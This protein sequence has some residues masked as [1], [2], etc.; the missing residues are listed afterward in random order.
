MGS[1]MGRSLLSS[2]GS[3]SQWVTVLVLIGSVALRFGLGGGGG[4]FASS[5]C[6]SGGVGRHLR[7]GQ[8]LCG[9]RLA[10]WFGCS[11]GIGNA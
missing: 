1:L 3:P 4:G 6:A 10:R 7:G 9:Q 8:R 5:R 2:T 11:L